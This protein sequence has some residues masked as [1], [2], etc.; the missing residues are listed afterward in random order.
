[1]F[2]LINLFSAVERAV[3]AAFMAIEVA[4]VCKLQ[5]LLR[6]ISLINYSLINAYFPKNTSFIVF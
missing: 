3:F 4:V 5:Q 2:L 6:R 1:M